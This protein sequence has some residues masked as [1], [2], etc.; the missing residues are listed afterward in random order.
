MHVLAATVGLSAILATSQSAFNIVKYLGASY[1][2][3]VGLRTI[4]RQP[5]TM[6]A[7][8]GSITKFQA[9]L[10]GFIVNTL[11]PESCIVF[12]LVSAAIY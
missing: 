9:F 11:E 8:A 2:V 3:L 10:Q 6:N 4:S 1:L 12:S 5:Q 7:A